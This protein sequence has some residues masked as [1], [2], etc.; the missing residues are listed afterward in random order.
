MI[1]ADTNLISE[2]MKPS[3]D[4]LVMSW[5]DKQETRHLFITSISVAE[6]YYG[7]TLLPEGRRQKALLA[8]FEESVMEAFQYRIL[9]FDDKAAF[10]YGQL[11]GHRKKIGRPMTVPDG[12]IAAIVRS[13]QMSL[14]TRNIRDFHECD[15]SLINPFNNV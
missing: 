7:L 3:P 4:S 8:A 14:A 2:W 6:I 1:I 9:H 15:I 11:M 13:N 5:L 10:I 12:Q